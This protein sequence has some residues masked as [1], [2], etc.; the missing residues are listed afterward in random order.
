MRKD[1]L[2]L[3]SGVCKHCK[4]IKEGSP[5]VFAIVKNG[6]HMIVSDTLY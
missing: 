3:H 1:V 2:S 6:D 5:Y 4:D